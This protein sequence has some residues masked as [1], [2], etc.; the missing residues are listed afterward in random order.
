MRL[1]QG[2]NKAVETDDIVKLVRQAGLRPTR[3]RFALASQ[4][5]MNGDR[6]VTAE[7]LHSESLDRG[8][9]ISLATVYNTLNRFTTAGLL[10]ELV[11]DSGRSYFDTN[12]SAHHHLYCEET[13]KL[14]DIPGDNAA[15]ENYLELPG[16][17]KVSRIDII[18]RVK[19][20]KATV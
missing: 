2:M 1:K 14:S 6:H 3:Q 19:N 20:S 7:Q 4:L 8:F 17:T 5:F 9:S 10:R 16:G 15:I 13:G 11:V 18:I 12:S